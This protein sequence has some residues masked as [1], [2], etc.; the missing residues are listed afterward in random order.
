MNIKTYLNKNNTIIYNSSINTSQNPVCELYYGD[1][2]SRLLI[3]FDTEKISSMI[4]DKTFSNLSKLK[5]ILKMKNCWGLQKLDSK[6]LF[7]SG[8]ETVKERTSSFDLYLVRMPEQW[9]SGSGN[10]YTKDGF[11]TKNYSI[12]ENGSNWFNSKTE[13]PWLSGDGIYT[14]VTSGDTNIVATQHFDVGYEDIEF[15]ITNEINNIITGNTENN[16]FMI[17]YDEKLEKTSTQIT[18]YVGFF[19]NNTNTF[20]KPYVETIYSEVINDD[21]GLFYLDKDNKLYFYSIIGGNHTNLDVIPSCTINNTTYNVKQA[22][23]GIY[24]VDVNLSSDDFESDKIM[25][26]TWSNIIYKG[27][28]LKNV[29]LE[30][31]VKNEDLF[32]NFNNQ[33][34]E[35][36][37]Y[38][39]TIYGVK[40]GEKINK[41]QILKILL[42]LR[43]EYTTETIKNNYNIEYRLYVKDMDYEITV[44]DYDSINKTF[45]EN[46]FMLF[47]DDLLPNRYYIDI[48]I[49]MFDT[50]VI[51]KE[52]FMFDVTDKT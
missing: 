22:T 25:F 17:C 15:D 41:S 33:N 47:T 32:Y 46:Y 28:T 4:D 48:K 21:R 36:T 11:L 9:S 16:G 12:S 51:H 50:E 20:F 35:Q 1:G 18:Q 37:K 40:F 43:Q 45:N 14:G 8:K 31:E 29:E 42:N 3:H 27:K 23:K 44:I 7:N 30:F 39:P 13:T 38:I 5:H 10:D 34:Y 19:T 52:K 49:K 6:I 2:Y 26:D 24:Y